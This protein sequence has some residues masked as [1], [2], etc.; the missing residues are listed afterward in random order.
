MRSFA[1]FCFTVLLVSC[2]A[3]PPAHEPPLP[4]LPCFAAESLAT[5]PLVFG[6][7]DRSDDESGDYSGLE[8][9]FVVDS[10]RRLRA[11]VRKAE[12]GLPPARP[13]D[14]LGY[15]PTKD[16]IWI[17]IRADTHSIM[18]YTYRPACTQLT[19]VAQLWISAASPRGSV[20]KADTLLR[21]IRPPPDSP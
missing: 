6:V 10:L 2:R 21:V 5:Q 8:V 17:S 19:G 13:V 12:G 7:I 11:L 18:R 9:R 15:D 16:S 4:A 20:I 1:R 3:Q 14:S